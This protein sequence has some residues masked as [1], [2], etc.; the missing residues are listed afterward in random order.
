MRNYTI[1]LIFAY[2]WFNF[3]NSYSQNEIDY[4]NSCWWSGYQKPAVDGDTLYIN[5][6][7]GHGVERWYINDPSQPLFIDGE[8]MTGFDI[9]DFERKLMIK[10]N[11]DKVRLADFSDFSN[12]EILS[13]ID[14]VSSLKTNGARLLGDYLLLASQD[15]SIRTYGVSLPDSPELFATVEFLGTSL[16]LGTTVGVT[17]QS[18][19]H[20]PI[21]AIRYIYDIS[22]PEDIQ[23]VRIDSLDVGEVACYSIASANGD[24]V[25]VLISNIMAGRGFVILRQYFSDGNSNLIISHYNVTSEFFYFRSTNAYALCPHYTWPR[26]YLYSFNSLQLLGK[27]YRNEPFWFETVDDQYLVYSEPTSLRFF[28]A[29]YSDSFMPE[30]YSFDLPHYGI[31]SSYIY[32]DNNTNNNYLLCGAESN[33]GELLFHEIDE[34]GELNLV[35]ILLDVGA[36]QIVF[37][38]TV[39]ICLCPSKIVAVDLSDLSAPQILHE[40]DGFDG[41]LKDFARGD[42]L[43]YAI[44]DRAYYIINYNYQDGFNILS[45]LYFPGHNLRSITHYH[46]YSWILL[47]PIGVVDMIYTGD[48]LNPFVRAE[49]RMPHP[50]YKYIKC[51]YNIWVSGE[52]GTDIIDRS[53]SMNSVAFIGPEYFSDVNQIYISNDTLYVADGKNGLKVFTFGDYPYEDLQFIGSYRTGNEIS[54]VSLLGDDFYTADYYSIHHLRWGEPTGIHFDTES[55]LPEYFQVFQNYP[56]PFNTSTIIQYNLPKASDVTIDIYDLLGRRIKTLVHQHQ[57]AGNHSVVWAAGEIA[58][59]LYFYKIQAGDFI[60]T[61]KMLLLK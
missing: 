60:Q 40:I 37:D 34:S 1:F 13:Q 28:E 38:S 29:T 43:I 32:T 2:V 46:M 26:S 10:E 16:A 25:A 27:F 57:L 23:L 58:S 61:R 45:S 42:S 6:L 30:I 49:K 18:I 20:H 22:Q 51:L 19:Y 59:G 8:A 35:S 36:T 31:L 48:P 53:V 52:Y 21:E 5:S 9:I 56:N 24:T 11:D 15:D 14:L 44:T 17:S 54:H 4:I 41:Q 55:R 50:S 12:I 3:S 47:G 7:N 33:D 39:A